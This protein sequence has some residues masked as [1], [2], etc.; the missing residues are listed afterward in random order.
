MVEK[1]VAAGVD[2]GF[3]CLEF[4]AH[5]FSHIGINHTLINSHNSSI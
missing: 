2:I 5:F 3:G 1:S 4:D